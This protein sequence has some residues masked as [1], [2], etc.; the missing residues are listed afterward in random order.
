MKYKRIAIFLKAAISIGILLY[1]IN[2]IDWDR[3]KTLG[4]EAVFGVLIAVVINLLALVLLSFR[5][6]KLLSM[7]NK[8]QLSTISLYKGY[9]VG[10]FFNIFLPGSI[11]GDVVRIKYGADHAGIGIKES[12]LIVFIERL[13]G[14]VALMLVFAVGVFYNAEM[15]IQ[16][17]M[18]TNHLILIAVGVV[19]ILVLVKYLV[20]RYIKIDATSFFLII[21]LSIIP[22]LGN[23]LSVAILA[24]S[25]GTTIALSK[26]LFILPLVQIATMLPI[27]LGGLGVREGV[28]AGLL[29]LFGIVTGDG[30]IISLMMFLAL[31]IVGLF[32]LPTV[33]KKL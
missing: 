30:V 11:G 31:V 18:Q 3:L 12:T 14:F 9:L 27:S 21:A 4:I 23:V 22:H 33:L 32:G 28:L 1:L 16:I 26:L 17:D 6:K 13:L 5:W 25:I 24:W 29:A 19:V 10:M 20:V 2:I 7:Q 15:L 8:K